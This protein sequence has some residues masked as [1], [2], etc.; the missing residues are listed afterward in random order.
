[1]TIAEE[2]RALRSALGENAATFAAVPFEKPSISHAA[3]AASN[4]GNPYR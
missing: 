4:K 1:M 2:V 3:R